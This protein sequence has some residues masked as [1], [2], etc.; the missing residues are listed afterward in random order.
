MPVD[1]GT[2]LNLMALAPLAVFLLAAGFATFA[3]MKRREFLAFFKR[4]GS[5]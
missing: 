3:A 2:G 5:A 4:I 1:A